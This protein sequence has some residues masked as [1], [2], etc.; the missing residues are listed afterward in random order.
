MPI[1]LG[2]QASCTQSTKPNK[3]NN[4]RA[5]AQGRATADDAVVQAR[6]SAWRRRAC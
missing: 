2:P 1:Y 3:I 5:D 6:A 4:T